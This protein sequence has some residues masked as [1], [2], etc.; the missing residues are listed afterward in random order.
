MK[1][2]L[3]S[4]L[5]F[6]FFVNCLSSP[7]E[8]I[9]IRL[10]DIETVKNSAGVPEKI[11]QYKY[12]DFNKKKYVPQAVLDLLFNNISVIRPKFLILKDGVAYINI[13]G[14]RQYI[15]ERTGSKGVGDFE[16]KIVFNLTEFENIEYVYFIDNGS[17]LSAGLRERIDFWNL[18]PSDEKSNYKTLIEDRLNFKRTELLLKY[19]NYLEEIGD[20][21]TIEELLYVKKSLDKKYDL[22]ATERINAV[23]EK[24]KN[25]QAAKQ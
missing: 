13:E 2:T 18:L 24:I 3:F 5:I 8:L 11:I 17:H 7:Q 16:A 25:V 10:W 23:I 12:I 21:N 20:T 22:Y 15:A 9:K 1:K 6:Q 19:L 14:D 4:L